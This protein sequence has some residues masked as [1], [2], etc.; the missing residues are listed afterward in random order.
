MD[1]DGLDNSELVM[2]KISDKLG[3]FDS[4]QIIHDVAVE[5]QMNKINPILS[6]C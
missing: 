4:H 3:K 6:H 2:M 1:N 5:Y